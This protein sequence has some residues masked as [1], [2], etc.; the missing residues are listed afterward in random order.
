MNRISENPVTGRKLTLAENGDLCVYKDAQWQRLGFNERFAGEFPSCTFQDILYARDDFY[1]AGTAD[2]GQA[3]LYSSL[4]GE[5][6]TPVN[7][8][9]QHYWEE[10]GRLPKGGAVKLF[11]EPCMDQIL[12][13]SAGGDV[14]IL[15]E[16]PKCVKILHL[17]DRRVTD[18]AYEDHRM[19]FTY[20]DGETETFSLATA[21]EIIVQINS[22]HARIYLY[23]PAVT[24]ASIPRITSNIL[25]LFIIIFII[26][27]R[28][29]NNPLAFLIGIF[30]RIF[31]LMN[32]CPLP[33]ISTVGIK[34]YNRI[35]ILVGFT[36]PCTNYSGFLFRNFLIIIA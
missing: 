14:A 33:L 24:I 7:L 29:H 11:F 9:E 8:T 6:W 13:V 16:C 27:G 18:A 28:I 19:T 1:A 23:Y 20:D 10:K 36:L 5:L 22:H 30:T 25:T 21:H 34:C 15:P 4:N 32:T 2:D 12:L 3:V 31:H 17:T 26:L 35:M